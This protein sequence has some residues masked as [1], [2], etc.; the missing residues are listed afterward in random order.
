M[1]FSFRAISTAIL[2]AAS[3]AGSALLTGCERKPKTYPQDTPDAVLLSARQML[4]DGRADRLHEL[5]YADTPDMR[6][7]LGRVGRLLRDIQSL[8]ET[9]QKKF[10]EDVARLREEAKTEGVTGLLAQI[11]GN[12]GRGRRRGLNM[13]QR[14][15]Q[16]AQFDG[17]IRQVL[18]DPYAWLQDNQGRLTTVPVNDNLVALQWDSKPIL[19]PLGIG[20]RR[21]EDK[22]FLVLPTNAPILSRFMPRTADE[23]KIFAM[24]FQS[25]GNAFRDVEK[26]INEGKLKTID[27]VSRQVGENAFVPMAMVFIAYG[28]MIENRPKAAPEPAQVRP[29]S[30]PATKAGG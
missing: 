28:K 3:L 16:S 14:E 25:L 17:L 12:Q 24:L 9:I 22:W 20:M 18:V 27:E 15:A 23:H 30:Q 10:P 4:D 7:T 11:G 1:S 8:A 19:P 6:K 29:A 5:I 21:E 2:L 13:D 26:D